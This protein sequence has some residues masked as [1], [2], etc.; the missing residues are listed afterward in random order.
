MTVTERDGAELNEVVVMA[1]EPSECETFM[2][3]GV[4][5]GTDV[6]FCILRYEM[7]EQM[8]CLQAEA[9]GYEQRSE[10]ILCEC[11]KTILIRVSGKRP[12]QG[13]W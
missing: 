11:G 12:T 4:I 8:L 3:W 6:G 13:R 10:M 9:N 1:A 7:D 2:R 5:V